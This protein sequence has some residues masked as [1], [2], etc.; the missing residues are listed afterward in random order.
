MSRKAKR[1]NNL[2]LLDDEQRA[3]LNKFQRDYQRAAPKMAELARTA[4]TLHKAMLDAPTWQIA[5]NPRPEEASE[6]SLFTVGHA[7]VNYVD[8][9]ETR[10]E[11]TQDR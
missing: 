7:K 2:H 5:E 6:P 4:Q 1:R 11:G 9:I 8:H 10:S 3:A